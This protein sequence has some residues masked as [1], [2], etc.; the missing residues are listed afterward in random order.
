MV[1]IRLEGR[2]YNVAEQHLGI[3]AGMGDHARQLPAI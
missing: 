1:H 2:S 3:Q